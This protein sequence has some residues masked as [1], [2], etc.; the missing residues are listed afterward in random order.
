LNVAKRL[1]DAEN[2]KD[3][4]SDE[5][6]SMETKSSENNMPH[7]SYPQWNSGACKL[8]RR[9][10]KRPLPPI[11]KFHYV[12]K[13]MAKDPEI[14]FRGKCKTTRGLHNGKSFRRS[15]FMGVSRNGSKWQTLLN[16]GNTKKYID[17]FHDE[18]EAAIT[19]DFYSIGFNG[20]KAKTNFTYTHS[21]LDEMYE[22]YKA[23][24]NIFNPSL[25]VEKIISPM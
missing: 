24:S 12:L 25:F 10:R 11:K 20:M 13:Q 6:K 7:D 23:N 2:P 5:Q 16:L 8:K 4:N 19:Y 9:P 18:N 14:T 1:Q 21:V 22:A 17:T 15:Q 3:L